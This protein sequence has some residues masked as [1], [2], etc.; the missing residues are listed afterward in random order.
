[1]LGIAFINALMRNIPWIIKK[2]PKQWYLSLS[3]IISIVVMFFLCLGN[4][5]NPTTFSGAYTLVYSEIFRSFTTA[6]MAFAG[7]FV[8]SAVYRAMRLKT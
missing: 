8:F 2:E 5:L 7:F 3:T 1:M 4:K 6:V